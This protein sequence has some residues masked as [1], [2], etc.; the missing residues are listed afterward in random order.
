MP[1]TQYPEGAGLCGSRAKGQ[2]RDGEEL[3]V[4]PHIE[5]PDREALRDGEV[6]QGGGDHR[7]WGPLELFTAINI[8]CMPLL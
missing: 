5:W 1:Q 3:T 7:L 4:R 8:W 2:R 6:R